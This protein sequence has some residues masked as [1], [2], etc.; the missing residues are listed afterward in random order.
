MLL[1][2]STYMHK[3]KYPTNYTIINWQTWAK[4]Q[5]CHKMKFTV[6]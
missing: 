4:M 2:K 1:E 3:L 5:H 6:P